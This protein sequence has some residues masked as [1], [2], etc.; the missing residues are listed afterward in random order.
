MSKKI[1]ERIHKETDTADLLYLLTA[2]PSSDLNSLLMEVMRRK[3]ERM[4]AGDLFRSYADNRFVKPSDVD[5]VS[6]LTFE[7]NLLQ[8]AQAIGFTPLEL[9]PVSPLGSCAVVATVNQNKILSALRSTEVVADAT[10][11]L[12]LEA[13]S[14]RKKTQFDSTDIHLCTVHRHLRT[15]YMPSPFLPHFKIFC[16]VTAG[17]DKGSLLFEKRHLIEHI[18]FTT[19]Y[20]KSFSGIESIKVVLKSTCKENLDFSPLCDAIMTETKDITFE[21]EEVEQP[22]YQVIQFKTFVTIRQK[23]FEIADGGLVDWSQKLANNRKERMLTSGIGIEL[24]FKLLG[25]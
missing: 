10:N 25:L 17:K 15:P 20:L 21:I 13:V 9:S 19:D 22:Y 18:R 5:F 1:I 8:R 23:E 6:F 12:A 14:R 3:T 16:L 7:L 11:L 4:T 2:L 24:L